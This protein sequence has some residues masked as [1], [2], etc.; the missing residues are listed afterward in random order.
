MQV[1]LNNAAKQLACPSF[2]PAEAKPAQQQDAEDTAGKAAKHADSTGFG[3]PAHCTTP[4]PDTE[5]LAGPVMQNSEQKD[6]PSSS[7]GSLKPVEQG[8]SPEQYA[9][10]LMSA[11]ANL[12][13]AM[14]Q[15]SALPERH[16]TSGLPEPEQEPPQHLQLVEAE[17]D[18]EGDTVP[19]QRGSVPGDSSLAAE[20]DPGGWSDSEAEEYDPDKEYD[21]SG[22]RHD[23]GAKAKARQRP[24][25]HERGHTSGDRAAPDEHAQS[26]VQRATL[27]FV[28]AI[29]NP[30][31]AAQV[32][33][34]LSQVTESLNLRIHPSHRSTCACMREGVFST[35]SRD[36]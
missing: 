30:L 17:I 1:Y 15:D 26:A 35:D 27:R 18:W 4:R 33:H 12:G 25:N 28:K 6:L 21:L 8:S 3:S 34:L 22:A 5:R 32:C 2:L 36:T 10:Q 23:P 14:G 24:A 29:L 13:S 9:G 11:G 16:Q 20:V 7:A 31:Y 19:Q